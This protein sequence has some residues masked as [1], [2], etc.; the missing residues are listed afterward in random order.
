MASSPW[1]LFGGA[2]GTVCSLRDEKL[3]RLLT[4]SVSLRDPFQINCD[5]GIF[6]MVPQRISNGKKKARL[7]SRLDLDVIEYPWKTN[8]EN[9]VEHEILKF[10]VMLNL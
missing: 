10:F 6:T 7:Y 5:Y 1:K 9:L 3:L 8:R 4:S 2:D